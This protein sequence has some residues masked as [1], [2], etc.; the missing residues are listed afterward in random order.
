M[1]V[2]TAPSGTIG[3]QVLDN[4]LHNHQEVRVIVRDAASL[5]PRLRDGVNVVEGSHGDER[6]VHSAFEGADAVFWLCPPNPNANSVEDAY[7]GFTKPAI[8]ALR[9]QQVARVVGISALGRSTPLAEHA[10]YVTGSLHMDDL[11]AT[12]GASY[13]AV[14]SPSFMDNLLRQLVP[15]VNHGKFFSTISGD[16]KLPYVATRDLAAEAARLLIDQSWQGVHE[17]PVLGAQDLSFNDMA[18][19][20]S[21]VLG[22]T[23]RFQQIPGD[24]FK[25]NMTAAGMS[26]AMAQGM[27]DMAT[28]K[29]NGLDDGL[30]RTSASSSPTSFRTWCEQVLR[31]A[32]AV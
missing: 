25:A 14:I 8:A 15:I 11:F 27:L 7:V 23:V 17:V 32:A 24:A 20:M 21:E 22:K 18:H 19:T 1:I 12:S 10:G 2:V 29:E 3:R 28:A 26:E 4:L 6:V 9:N 13:R 30:T 31:P 5:P 16:R